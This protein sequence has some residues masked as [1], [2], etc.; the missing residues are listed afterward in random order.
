MTKEK[1]INEWN[2][3]GVQIFDICN[4]NKNR[5]IIDYPIIYELNQK[6]IFKIDSRINNRNNIVEINNYK[7]SNNANIIMSSNNC[8]FIKGSSKVEIKFYDKIKVRA[9][10]VF[11]YY[12]EPIGHIDIFSDDKY[13]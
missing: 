13:I 11:Q 4:Q 3:E 9:K 7:E 5:Q 10:N 1:I 6:T 2:T 8:Q 12:E